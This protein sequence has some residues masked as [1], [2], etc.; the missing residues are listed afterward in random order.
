MVYS[1]RSW[2]SLGLKYEL[3]SDRLRIQTLL[4]FYTLEIIYSDIKK[5]DFGYPTVFWDAYIKG[6]LSKKYGY[7]A[8]ILKNDLADLCKHLVIEKKTGFF[9]QVRITPKSPEK[10][11]K[12]LE[13]A[14]KNSKRI[15]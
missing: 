14:I 8:R 6:Q 5:V 11:K 1:E 4:P 3:C 2:K 12:L 7:G 13:E 10:F 15:F 9:K